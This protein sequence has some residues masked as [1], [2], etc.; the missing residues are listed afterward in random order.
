MSPR[1]RRYLFFLISLAQIG[2]GR[3][4]APMAAI[5]DA[6]Y[7]A[8]GQTASV[9]TLRSAL[10]ELEAAGYIVRRTCRLGEQRS[11]AVIDLVPERFVY[12]TKIQTHN[13]VP[14]V[15]VSQVSPCRQVLPTDDRRINPR[16]N[17][18]SYTPNNDTNVQEPRANARSKSHAKKHHYH[19]IVYTL[20][21]V[22]SGAGRARA[23]ELATSELAGGENRSGVDW[24]YYTRLW[25]SLDCRPG[26]R[27][28]QTARSEIVPLLLRCLTTP[29][30]TAEIETAEIET[31]E[32][33]VV[34]AP[35]ATAEQ[36]SALISTI[37]GW[38]DI[39]RVRP[40][41]LGNDTEQVLSEEE[42]RVLLAA[43]E[44]LLKYRQ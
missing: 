44:R 8:Q 38:R 31:A 18:S 13:V 25:R 19:P 41:E 27:R 43:R 36:I 39:D 37:S 28:E 3:I 26:G 29:P 6:I 35:P 14:C 34:T 10:A 5:A 11:H 17:S 4:E 32:I 42:R 2:Y 24:E 20:L 21:C 23:I 40:A 16:V 7:R 12:W 30:A 9:R 33:K 1:A 15:P 22:M